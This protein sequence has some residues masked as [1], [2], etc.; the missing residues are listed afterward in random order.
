MDASVDEGG[1]DPR[2][3]VDHDGDHS[4]FLGPDGLP[5]L[6]LITYTDT[7]G[8]TV[9]RLCEDTTGL[10]IGP[11]DRRLPTAGIYVSQLRG[12]AYHQIACRAGDFTPGHPVMLMR[13]PTNAYD[14]NAIAVF[15]ATA[16]HLAAYVNK[17]KARMLARLLD[18]GHPLRAISIRGTPASIDCEQVAILA[19]T[20]SVVDL[21]MRTRPSSLPTP[22]HLLDGTGYDRD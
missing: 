10:L 11:T 16:T 9:L 19:A 3:Y 21:L 17:Q 15:D 12:E 22:A 20:P 2:W 14:K 18:A 1:A 13:E 4:R 7:H 5:A 6:H 8:E